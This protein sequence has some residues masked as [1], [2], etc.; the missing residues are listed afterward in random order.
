[1][2]DPHTR[3]LL[4]KLLKLLYQC[5]WPDPEKFYSAVKETEDYLRD[6]KPAEEISDDENER[7]F[8]QCM[9]MINNLQPGEIEALMGPEFMEEFRRVSQ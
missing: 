4:Q 6:T 5:D 2:S 9:D 1:M 3:N 7:R 8:K